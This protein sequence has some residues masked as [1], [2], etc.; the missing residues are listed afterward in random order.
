MI[1]LLFRN[2]HYI[3]D[4]NN[5]LLRWGIINMGIIKMGCQ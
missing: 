1:M 5:I 3:L 2:N 4:T